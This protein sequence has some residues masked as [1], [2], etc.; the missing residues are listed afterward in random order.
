M[1]Q[2]EL[3]RLEGDV[4][5]ARRRLTSDL[6][7]LRAPGTFTSFKDELVAEARQSGDDAITRATSWSERLLTEIKERA[8]ANPLAVGAIAAGIGWRILRKPPIT[9]MLVGY[10]VYS[11][12]RTQPGQLAPGAETV[13]QAIDAAVTAKEQVQQ[14]SKEAGE[15]VAHVR[16]VVVPAV[17]DTVQRWT[18]E[19]GEGVAEATDSVQALASSTSERAGRWGAD[20]GATVA[21]A[22]GS[23]EAAALRGAQRIQ[24]VAMDEQQREKVLLGAAAVALTTALWLAWL[25]RHEP[26][27]AAFESEPRWA[28]HSE[29]TQPA[30]G[31]APAQRHTTAEVLERRSVPED[32]ENG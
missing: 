24:H 26:A 13:Y 27:E 6:E 30:V 11:L 2:S 18:G 25:R 32:G 10:G 17:T 22:T 14:W 12:F 20:V 7:V 8:A 1:A 4:H 29:N 31:R 23:L 28:R 19:A 3:D 21:E 9:T 5:E 15:A 16:D